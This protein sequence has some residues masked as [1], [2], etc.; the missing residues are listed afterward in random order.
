MCRKR[1]RE[2]K[3]RQI[4][5]EKEKENEMQ[6]PDG[7][8]NN[9]SNLFKRIRRLQSKV[10]I[11]KAKTLSFVIKKFNATWTVN[12]KASNEVGGAGFTVKRD[13]VFIMGGPLAVQNQDHA[14]FTHSP[15]NHNGQTIKLD[16]WSSDFY[17]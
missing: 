4:E 2:E 5:K 6:N 9:Y 8:N 16:R 10:K 7:H 14:S 17:Y 3:K 11:P 15:Y 13:R 12:M 1:L